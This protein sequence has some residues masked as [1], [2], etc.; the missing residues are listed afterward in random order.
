MSEVPAAGAP[1]PLGPRAWY[2]LGSADLVFLLLCVLIYPAAQGKMLSDPG[3]GWHLRNIDAMLAEGGWLTVDPFTQPRDGT[4]SRWYTN[5]WL[6][7]LPFWLGE[8]WAGMEGIAAVATVVLAFTL[9]CVYAAL[10]RDGLPWPLAAAWVCVAAVGT[11]C[12]WIARPNLFT[13]LFV[14]LTARLCE[15]FHAGRASKGTLLWLLL[16]FAVWANTHG[17]FIAGFIVLAVTLF[18]E[19]LL[20]LFASGSARSAARSRLGWLSL[21]CLGAFC[22]TLLNPY[23]W[24]LYPWIF[25][26]LGDPYFMKLHFEWKPPPFNEPGGYQFTLLILLLP[27]MLGLSKKNP[28]PVE[29]GLAV[30]WLHFGLTGFRYF[31]L[32]ALVAVPVMARSSMAIPWIEK[33][34]ASLQ[35]ASGPE[36]PIALP[37]RSPW[38]WTAVFAA[39]LILA[40]VFIKGRYARLLPDMIPTEAL[41]ELLKRHEER[42]SVAV[43]HSYDWGGY[44]TWHGWH[45]NGPRLLNWIDDR[46]E[47]QGR[48][49]VEE[50]YSILDA[51]PGWEQKLDR[52]RVELIG[53]EAG[54]PLAQR[55]NKDAAGIGVG[56]SVRVLGGEWQ[57]HQVYSSEK[58]RNDKGE[59]HGAVV[60]ERFL[61]KPH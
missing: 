17:G 51:Q 11:N 7:E 34:F 38:V 19:A 59:I 6:G 2:R 24:R 12:S 39:L 31:P 47:V 41:D 48:E 33:C 10:L 46:N 42:P 61:E 36:Q 5:Q 14:F 4:H 57:W 1:S 49:H 40:S 60:F 3:L 45:S 16:L 26:L 54:A 22:A 35:S 25:Q 30:V 13:M 52:D 9:R 53:I 43:F 15:Q 21:V 20:S 37:A 32:C 28:T 27:L 44:L 23:G 8:R 55:L 56:G 18:I 50:Y 58:E 29:L